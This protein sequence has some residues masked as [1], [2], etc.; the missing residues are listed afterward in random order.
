VLQI[1]C[2]IGL[3][4]AALSKGVFMHRFLM[5]T[6]SV[7]LEAILREPAEG[8][9]GAVVVCHPHPVY[10]GTMDNRVVYRTAKAAAQHG[11]AALRFNFRGVGESTGQFD[12]GIGE[13][14]DAAAA[15][16]W[17]GDRF[18]GFDLVMA[19]Y[20]FGAWVGL[21]VGSA[22]PRVKALLGLGLPLNMYDLG[23]L[24]LNSK[25]SLYIVGTMDEL[26]S[27]ENLDQFA[28]RLPSTSSVLRVEGSDHFFNGHIDLV[29]D[30]MAE[31]FKRL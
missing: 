4:V 24:V 22:A 25:P 23:Y 31:F 7:Q 21:E 20:S 6:G 8:L 12:H 3:P 5:D 10:G 14:E 2:G 13:R 28:G 29:E 27:P 17:L 26:C 15:L 19:G 9:R 16:R 11:Y 1:G 18:P 30:M